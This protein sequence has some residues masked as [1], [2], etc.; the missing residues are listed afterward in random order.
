MVSKDITKK[1]RIPA[2]FD[3]YIKITARLLN[4]SENDA[5]K[6][7]IFDHMRTTKYKVFEDKK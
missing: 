4:I 2:G 1:I 6:M 7:I 3:D 5:I